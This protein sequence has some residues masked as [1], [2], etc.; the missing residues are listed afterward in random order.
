M[1]G[2]YRTFLAL[3]VV[4]LHLG[5]LPRIGAYAVFG[6]YCLSGY[7]ITLIMQTNYGYTAKGIS[8]Y[9]LNRFL[10]IYP[11]YWISMLFSGALIWCLGN[12]YTSNY[13]PSIY[14]P[15]NFS[16]L[17]KNVMLFF[18]F[19]EFPRLTPPAWALTVELFFYGLMG[20]G[21][22][23]NKCITTFWFISSVLYHIGA[24]IL[25][26]GWERRYFT[27]FAASL[28]FSTGALIYHYKHEVTHFLNRITGKMYRYFP[29][30]LCSIILLNW[31]V[32]IRS[33]QSTG[34]YFYSNYVLC[35]L[36][37]AVLLSRKELPLISKRFDKWLG[38]F[39]YPIYLIHYQVGL[40]VLVILGAFGL[41]LKRPDL[42]LMFIS[43]PFIFAFSWM[44]TVA[45]ERPIEM[46]RSKIKSYK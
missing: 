3:M 15:G 29:V 33:N 32:G 28:P 44:I 36:M 24:W 17:I 1:F 31:H 2:A 39:S 22:S 43:I 7:L 27:I 11:I 14:L 26:L 10:R 18:P 20:V 16:E 41:E 19:R 5:G 4:A 35:S 9:A 46:I 23:K 37:V 25:Q 30:L 38:D 8:K 40:L 34:T 42:T 45:V 12:A 21:L 6:F 13:H